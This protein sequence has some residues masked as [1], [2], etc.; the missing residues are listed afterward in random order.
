M[1]R[2]LY[3]LVLKVTHGG[4]QLRA[5]Y[6][7]DLEKTLDNSVTAGIGI[8]PFDLLSLDIAGAYAGANQFGV[9]GNLAFTF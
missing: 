7:M 5:G 2:N 3:V 4:A 9:S 6:E 1:T 8:S